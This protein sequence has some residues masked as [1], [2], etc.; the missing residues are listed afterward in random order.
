VLH[1]VNGDQFSQLYPEGSPSVFITESP[2]NFNNQ[3]CA[4]VLQFK[5]DGE[6]EVIYQ[7]TI[8]IFISCKSK[9]MA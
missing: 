8:Y 1:D 5:P 6:D 4:S 3:S 7:I 2:V 9:E